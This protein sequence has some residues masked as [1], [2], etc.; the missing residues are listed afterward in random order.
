MRSHFILS[1][2]LNI[3]ERETYWKPKCRNI[4]FVILNKHLVSPCFTRSQGLLHIKPLPQGFCVFVRK[5]NL[6][7]SKYCKKQ[8]TK[9]YNGDCIELQFKTSSS[10]FLA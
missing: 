9:C 3:V 2:T 4:K 8:D 10:D 5:T 7:T 1:S 6:L